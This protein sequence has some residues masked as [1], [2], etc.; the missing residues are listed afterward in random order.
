MIATLTGK[1]LIRG[2]DRAVIDVAGVGYEVF[3]TTDGLTRLPDSSEEVFLHISTQVREDA[4]VLYGFLDSEEKDMFLHLT[5]VSGIGPKLGLAA[6]SGMRVAEL[7]RAIAARDIKLLSSM[8][9]VGKK[10]AERICVELKDKVGDLVAGGVELVETTGDGGPGASSTVADVLS[11][12]G[13]LGYSDPVSRKSLTSVK[14][15]LG[16]ETFYAL[17]VEDLIRECLRSMA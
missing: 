13:N 12:L 4:I 1:V 6:L 7:C 9:G 11:A 17:S 10:T 15:R 5:S 2:L 8:Q 16:D 3:L 14:R